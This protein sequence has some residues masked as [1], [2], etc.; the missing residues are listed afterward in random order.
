MWLCY[1][2]ILCVWQVYKNHLACNWPFFRAFVLSWTQIY[3]GRSVLSLFQGNQIQM[4]K[5]RLISLCLVC[6][7][8]SS[9][10]KWNEL[11][12]DETHGILWKM[13][14]KDWRDHWFHA[15]IDLV[16][17]IV[18]KG[19][20]LG[21]AA[22]LSEICHC[23]PFWVVTWEVPCRTSTWRRSS[24]VDTRSVLTKKLLIIVHSTTKTTKTYS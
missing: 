12:P 13:P 23:S 19:E 21:R 4:Y 24:S 22:R 20:W 17:S 7:G 9:N 1:F 3:N 2:V 10:S 16:S 6:T 14:R 5:M 18:N 11:L 15:S 8:D